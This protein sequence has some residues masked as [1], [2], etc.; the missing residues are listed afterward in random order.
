MGKPPP[1]VKPRHFDQSFAR[2]SMTGSGD[3]AFGHNISK[4]SNVGRQQPPPN[5]MTNGIAT[6]SS[7]PSINPIAGVP[8]APMNS[9]PGAPQ[10][11]M[12]SMPGAPQPPMNSML[13]APQPPMNPIPGAPQ[14]PMNSIPSAPQPP[15]NPIPSVSPIDSAQPLSG[16]STIN[17]VSGQS[18][19]VGH[20]NT[21][22]T[23]NMGQSAVSTNGTEKSPMSHS[24]ASFGS[25]SRPVPSPIHTTIDPFGNTIS[26]EATPT[27]AQPAAGTAPEQPGIAPQQQQVSS[28]AFGNHLQD[29]TSTTS[30]PLGGAAAPYHQQQSA[31]NSSLGISQNGPQS[32][33]FQTTPASETG[34]ASQQYSAPQSVGLPPSGGTN[35]IPQESQQ[36]D[37]SVNNSINL[38]AFFDEEPIGQTP[39][40]N[41]SKGASLNDLF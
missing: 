14:P 38:S 8:Q 40:G 23:N 13:G 4:D 19:K 10:P 31:A 30:V 24:T 39:I 16:D 32:G 34:V 26:P 6:A 33:M 12:N 11:P 17:M 5:P 1:K 27:T 25:R 20:L 37:Q 41:A 35:E 29:Q 28:T 7:G 2:S 15:M 9:I 18:S 3:A 22:N 36:P 21:V